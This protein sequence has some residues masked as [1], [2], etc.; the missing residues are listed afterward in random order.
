MSRR[1]KIGDAAKL[2]GL[3]PKAVRHYEALGLLTPERSE[4]G[5]RLY[6]ADE[7]LRLHRIKRLRELGLSLEQVREVLAAPD[8]GQTL[9]RALEALHAGVLEEIRHL[10]DRRALLEAL[11]AREDLEA[12]DTSPTMRILERHLGEHLHDEVS[13][14]L[15]E[16]ERRLWATLDAFRWPAEYGEA[17]ES[18][19][20][21][22]AQHPEEYRRE[23]AIAGRVA[24]I[25]D[26]PED[27][28]EVEALARECARRYR[29]LSE[30]EMTGGAE[31]VGGAE[32]EVLVEIIAS[33]LA[34][35]QRRFVELLRKYL[36][37]E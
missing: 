16:R 20:R 1:L 13:P 2:A 30:E 35:A 25:A 14:E 17:I 19:A 24:D 7:L 36:E 10:Q 21:Y 33:Q 32:G 5:Y 4:S 18:M 11:L 28:P 37:E 23:L 15:L 6:G 34:P 12:P 22:F 31:G 3:T 27:A 9:R 26:L 29:A 8:G